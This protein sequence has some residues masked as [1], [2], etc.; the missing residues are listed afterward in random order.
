[1]AAGDVVCFQLYNGPE[2]ALL[3]LAAQRLGAIA[4]PVNFR[5]SPGETAYILDASRPASDHSSA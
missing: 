2:F 5:L 1:V 3:W 4:S